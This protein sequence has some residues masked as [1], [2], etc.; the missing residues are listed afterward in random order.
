VG[1][2]SRVH[3][4]EIADMGFGYWNYFCSCGAQGRAITSRDEIAEKARLHKEQAERGQ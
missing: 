3:K 1:L 4:V 2:F